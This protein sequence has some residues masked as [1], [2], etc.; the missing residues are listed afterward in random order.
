[1]NLAKTKKEGE[2]GLLE[3]G[4]ICKLP[5]DKS[6]GCLSIDD[7]K[8]SK[9]EFAD[10]DPCECTHSCKRRH[11]TGN[12]LPVCFTHAIAIG[13]YC[14]L[15]LQLKDG[16]L[17]SGPQVQVV[18]TPPWLSQCR[19]EQELARGQMSEA[20]NRES[21]FSALKGM[22]AGGLSYARTAIRA[23]L[24]ERKKDQFLTPEV[25]PKSLEDLRNSDTLKDQIAGGMRLCYAAEKH[26]RWTTS[27][28]GRWFSWKRSEEKEGPTLASIGKTCNGKAFFPLLENVPAQTSCWKIQSKP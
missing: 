12:G 20:Y 6:K 21:R 26:D 2:F 27:K 10:W 25:T 23:G 5:D 24:A 11:Y 14:E 9:P 19:H 28:K 16:T 4:K 13:N 3:D 18:R 17:A 22:A 8:S 7:F 15:K 1:M